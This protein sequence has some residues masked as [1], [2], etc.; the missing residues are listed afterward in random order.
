MI[1]SKVEAIG[2]R[3]FM[4]GVVVEDVHFCYKSM[5]ILMYEKK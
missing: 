2:G 5:M 3:M 1:M 4:R